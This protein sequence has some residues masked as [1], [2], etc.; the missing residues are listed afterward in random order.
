MTKQTLQKLENKVTVDGFTFELQD[1]MYECRGELLYDDEH[2]EI[3][4]PALW[5]AAVKLE[6]ELER[7]GYCANVG[8]SEKGW[9]EIDVDYYVSR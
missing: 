6:A 4:E 5:A 9:V 7:Q 3:P 1:D 2:D 8:H